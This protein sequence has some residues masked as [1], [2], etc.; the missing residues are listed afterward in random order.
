MLPSRIPSIY[1][2]Y[3]AHIPAPAHAHQASAHGPNVLGVAGPPPHV[4]A[5]GPREP[6][7]VHH[8]IRTVNI[9]FSHVF[10]VVIW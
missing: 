10:S 8:I 5:D 6:D 1:K 4:A 2:R 3:S 9:N 7:A